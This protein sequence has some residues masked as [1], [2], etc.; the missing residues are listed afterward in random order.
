MR[1]QMLEAALVTVDLGTRGRDLALSVGHQQRPGAAISKCEH[2]MC[3]IGDELQLYGSVGREDTPLV[4][5]KGA[6][7]SATAFRYRPPRGCLRWLLLRP[8]PG[9]HPCAPLSSRCCPWDP[10]GCTRASPMHGTCSPYLM[11]P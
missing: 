1:R 5:G 8:I 2:G 7:F 3:P 9:A 6:L 11:G 10:D 4:I